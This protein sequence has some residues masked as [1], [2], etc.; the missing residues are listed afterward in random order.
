MAGRLSGDAEVA[1]RADDA[2]AEKFLPGA[3]DSDSGGQGV[4]GPEQPTGEPET[5]LG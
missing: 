3:V 5:V 1:R 4:L 2:L